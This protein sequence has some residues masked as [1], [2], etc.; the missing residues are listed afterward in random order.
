MVLALDGMARHMA[1]WSRTGVGFPD[2]AD[3]SA[4]SMVKELLANLALLY[5]AIAFNGQWLSETAAGGVHAAL[6]A[7]GCYHQAL[8]SLFMN[9]GRKL[10][11]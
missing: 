6:L 3:G 10:S 11:T 7:A 9:R 4:Y 1:E 2:D 5:N 8:C